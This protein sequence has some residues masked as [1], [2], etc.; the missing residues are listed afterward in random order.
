LPVRLD[1]LGE[2]PMRIDVRRLGDADIVLV[3]GVLDLA[4]TPRLRAVLTARLAEDRPQIVVDLARVRIMDARAVNTLVATANRA[5]RQGCTLRAVGARGLVLGVL[6]IVG[7]DKRLRAHD[8]PADILAE[9]AAGEQPDADIYGEPS[10]RW[11]GTRDMSA[12][13]LLSALPY[14]EGPARAELRSQVIEDHMPFATRLAR[15][16]RDRGE[17]M[18]DL[19]QVAL[20]G[21]V[22]SVDGYDPQR[23]CEF[24]GYA[25]PTILGEIRRYFRDKGWRIKVPRRLQERRLLVNRAKVELSQKLGGSPTVADIAKHL[26]L[27]EDEVLEAIQ[28]AHVYSPMSLSAPAGP[29]SDL[30]LADPLGEEDPGLEVV[31]NRESVMPLLARLPKREQRI[32]AMRFFGNMTQSQI[33]AELGI[34]QM[35]VSRLLSQT[36]RQL[37]DSL[38][39]V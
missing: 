1:E 12:H 32:L 8:E 14:A 30:D 34:S 2:V 27:T 23:G 10:S 4:T 13:G 3:E 29:D 9:L 33:A 25:T 19:I 11:P 21:L 18:D 26:E 22:N 24:A 37:R 15:R 20:V 6:Q 36:L 7:L 35:H 31:E 38:V 5:D 39:E 16:F 17:P 28:V